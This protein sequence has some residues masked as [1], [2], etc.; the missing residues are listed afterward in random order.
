MIWFAQKNQEVWSMVMLKAQKLPMAI[1]LSANADS[2]N[3]AQWGRIVGCFSLL[4]SWLSGAIWLPAQAAPLP[5]GVSSTSKSVYIDKSTRQFDQAYFEQR[6]REAA[7]FGQ[8]QLEQARIER[9]H[10]LQTHL[11]QS[12]SQLELADAHSP[13]TAVDHLADGSYLYGQ[14]PIPDQLATAYFV[15]ELQGGSITGAFY[16]PSSS[17]DCVQGQIESE[18]ILLS[19]TDSYSQET[20]PYALSLDA[21]AAVVASQSSVV[22]APPN[23]SG[24][25][26]LPMSDQS[27]ELLAICL[28]K[29]L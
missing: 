14:Q 23:I 29:Y 25:Y 17:F 12:A 5:Q 22:N 19:V 28:A 26:P 21:Q 8:L 3:V 18:Q 9:L 16:M 20:S 24:F 15:F 6:R 4:A 13:S 11:G 10:R 1:G 2:L 27:R 7:Q